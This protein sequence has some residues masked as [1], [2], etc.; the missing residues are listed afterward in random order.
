MRFSSHF[1]FPWLFY[2]R[3]HAV[4]NLTHTVG[5]TQNFCSSRNFDDVWMQTRTGR[6]RLAWKWLGQLEQRYPRLAERAR[7]LNKRDK[8]YMKYDPEVQK[9]REY[10]LARLEQKRQWHK[11]EEKDN[12]SDSDDEEEEK[13]DAH[14]EEGNSAAAAP[15]AMKDGG[16]ALSLINGGSKLP[17][18]ILPTSTSSQIANLDREWKRIRINDEQSPQQHKAA[19][20]VSPPA[21]TT[22]QS[23]HPERDHPAQQGRPVSPS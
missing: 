21:E 4:L 3:W 16:R 5:I 19:R 1:P 23:A 12:D 8:F 11:R 14:G 17:Q 15:P 22:A 6:K 18:F 7:A 13:K 2:Y 9:I 20:T 10:A